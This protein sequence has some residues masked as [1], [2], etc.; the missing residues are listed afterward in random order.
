M[1][2]KGQTIHHRIFGQGQVTSHTEGYL[3]V[4]FPDGEKEFVFPTAFESFLSVEDQ[5]LQKEIRKLVKA[6]ALEDQAQREADQER[7]QESLRRQ[8][9]PRAGSKAARRSAPGHVAFKCTYCD[10]GSDEDSL[11]FLGPCSDNNIRR[12]ILKDKRVWCS[13]PDCLCKTY[14]EGG[15]TRKSLDAGHQLGGFI[16][17]ES[18]MLRDWRAFAGVNH[19]GQKA[20][21][22]RRLSQVGPNSLCLLTTRLPGSKEDERLIFAAFLADKSYEG[23]Q[24]EAGYVAAGEGSRVSLSRQEALQ[25]PFWRY[26]ANQNQPS[27]SFWGS[28]LFRYLESAQAA[29]V[30]RDIARLKLGK[31]EQ[32]AADK[33]YAD[34]CALN[35]LD[36]A[37]LGEPQGALTRR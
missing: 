15:I 24:D 10:G 31:P 18:A 32:A 12:N 30:L 17:Y 26:H 34:F 11:G 2:L 19:T 7:I 9:A 22:A 14:L 33:L 4:R 21:A 35:H 29:L 20:G 36:Q 27:K 25:M 37:A 8:A 13:A 5:A 23:D 1:N 3:T 16:C 6:D 28:G